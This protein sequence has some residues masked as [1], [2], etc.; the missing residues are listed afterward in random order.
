MS[1]RDR[2]HNPDRRTVAAAPAMERRDGTEDRREPVVARW[3]RIQ[4][5]RAERAGGDRFTAVADLTGRAA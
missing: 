3:R 1:L 5:E 2:I 4:L